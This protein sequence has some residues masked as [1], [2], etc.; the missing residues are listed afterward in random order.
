MLSVNVN[1]LMIAVIIVA[2]CTIGLTNYIGNAFECKSKKRWII[3]PVCIICGIVNTPLVHPLIT[4]VFNIVVL[5]FSLATI[6]YDIIKEGLPRL[7]N[8]A[9]SRLESKA[10]GR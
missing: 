6:C 10:G 8:S 7:V 4:A 1:D 2:I 9:F 5:A 3:L